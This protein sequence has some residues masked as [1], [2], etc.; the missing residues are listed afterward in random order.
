MF[1][2]L[3]SLSSSPLFLSLFL[4]LETQPKNNRGIV[5]R[6]LEISMTFLDEHANERRIEAN[7]VIAGIL[8]HEFDH[9]N[10][11]L[12]ISRNPIFNF[13]GDNYLL[14]GSFSLH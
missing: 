11:V 6:H 12:F 13:D 3:F 4:F 14:K 9:L 8:Q 10:G 5:K 2:S 1:V 7:G